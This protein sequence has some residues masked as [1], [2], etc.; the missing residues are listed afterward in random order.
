MT[1]AFALGISL[2]L[3]GSST[4]CPS[5]PQT[6]GRLQWSQSAKIVAPNGPWE[7]VVHRLL[8]A[9]ENQS[10]VRLRRCQGAGSW[11][12]LTLQRSA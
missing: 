11:P 2:L 1:I 7:V 3:A 10:P 4:Q 6:H 12:L 8:T 9:D 5:A